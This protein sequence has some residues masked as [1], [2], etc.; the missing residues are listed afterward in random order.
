MHRDAL[1]NDSYLNR[2]RLAPSQAERHD[3]SLAILQR[4]PTLSEN[5]FPPQLSENHGECNFLAHWKAEPTKSSFLFQES[6]H[7]R[8]NLPAT[9]SLVES[10]HWPHGFFPTDSKSERAARSHRP[11]ASRSWD[12]WGIAVAALDTSA[13]A[14]PKS[15][16][17]EDSPKKPDPKKTGR[18]ATH[19]NPKTQPNP[20]LA[21]ARPHPRSG[22]A[23]PP[24]NLQSTQSSPAPQRF[25]D[26]RPQQQNKPTKKQSKSPLMP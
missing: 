12:L 14:V 22:R 24:K 19:P 18:P 16:P 23:F 26:W 11:S 21:T 3:S 17:N 15:S 8:P 9:R 25:Y 2:Y 1:E 5:I 10:H 13:V 7:L 6:E 4:L 20:K